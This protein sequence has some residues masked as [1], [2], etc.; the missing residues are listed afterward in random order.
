VAAEI[1]WGVD[2]GRVVEFLQRQP[3]GTAESML[4]SALD[5]DDP[6]MQWLVIRAVQRMQLPSGVFWPR[7]DAEFRREMKW[8]AEQGQR[9][10]G[11]GANMQFARAIIAAGP[12]AD[13]Y[14]WEWLADENPWVRSAALQLLEPRHLRDLEFLDLVAQLLSEP[15]LVLRYEV[16]ATIADNWWTEFGPASLPPAAADRLKE[17]LR[18]SHVV[19]YPAFSDARYDP[20][21]TVARA[22]SVTRTA[23]EEVVPLLVHRVQVMDPSLEHEFFRHTHKYFDVHGCALPQIE[24]T[25]MLLNYGEPA[26]PGL[27]ELARSPNRGI[28]LTA[29][30][31]ANNM[32]PFPQSARAKLLALA[33]DP[34][35]PLRDH[36]VRWL[37][38]LEWDEETFGFVMDVLRESPQTHLREA[39]AVALSIHGDPRALE[40][41][42]RAAGYDDDRHVRAAA[43]EGIDSLRNRQRR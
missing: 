12:A 21:L 33:K 5:V 30:A 16:A 37:G 10:T 17:L 1:S 4:L 38:P 18:L 2:I 31:E 25:R 36:A 34:A 39:A 14:L 22:L 42:R 19:A 11:F 27:L 8:A 40:L 20:Y 29:H 3:R 32:A 15:N 13:G 26:L 28:R 9:G 35:C 23:P 6:R 24:L 43:S 7:F 41:L